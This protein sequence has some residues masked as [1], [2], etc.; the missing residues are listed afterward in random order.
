MRAAIAKGRTARFDRL[1]DP[2]DLVRRKI[3]DFGTVLHRADEQHLCHCRKT[4]G[5]APLP[6]SVV[7]DKHR[8]TMPNLKDRA[9]ASPRQL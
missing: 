4:D 5:I 6:P 7:V 9:A 2:G 8:R 1:A 3:V